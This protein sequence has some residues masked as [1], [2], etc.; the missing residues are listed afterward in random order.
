MVCG[1]PKPRIK[2]FG[3]MGRPA[4]SEIG[5]SVTI[6]DWSWVRRRSPGRIIV[7]DH[8]YRAGDPSHREIT[9]Y[10]FQRTDIHGYGK[11]G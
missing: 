2:C 6:A 9:D 3:P 1:V 11:S 8:T 10:L 5:L 4:S 7:A